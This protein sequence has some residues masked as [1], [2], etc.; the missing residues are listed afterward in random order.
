MA[1]FQYYLELG[2]PLLTSSSCQIIKILASQHHIFKPYYG[3]L[4]NYLKDE[5][6]VYIHV[7]NI[8]QATFHLY[9]DKYPDKPHYNISILVNNVITIQKCADRESCEPMTDCY[10][11]V[12]LFFF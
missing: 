1:D 7:E 3:I 9:E 10:K 8:I 4:E 6:N 2:P 12:R 5:E 11:G